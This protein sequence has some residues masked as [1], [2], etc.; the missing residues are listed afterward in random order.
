MKSIVREH[1]I[2]VESVIQEITQKSLLSMRAG[3]DSHLLYRPGLHLLL[4]PAATISPVR[5]F[6]RQRT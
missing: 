2:M 4:Y 1:I 6:A 5:D 3:R